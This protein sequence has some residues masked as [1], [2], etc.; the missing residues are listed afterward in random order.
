MRNAKQFGSAMNIFIYL[1]LVT[2]AVIRL[3]RCFFNCTNN[4]QSTTNETAEMV[5]NVVT[6]ELEY[7][8]RLSSSI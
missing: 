3:S 5:F 1:N 6:C 7:S 8:V 4:N 2:K